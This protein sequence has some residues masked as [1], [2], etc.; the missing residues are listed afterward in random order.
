MKSKI[1]TTIFLIGFT[2]LFT[3]VFRNPWF[4]GNIFIYDLI[5]AI[6]LSIP[7]SLVFGY[8]FDYIYD[9]FID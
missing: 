7:L 3:W 4:T 5:A 9:R 2:T 1:I 8:V 6:G